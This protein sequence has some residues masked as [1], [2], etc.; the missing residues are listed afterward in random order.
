MILGQVGHL[1]HRL[2]SECSEVVGLFDY[3]ADWESEGAKIIAIL[4][5]ILPIDFR[6]LIY[7]FRMNSR[8]LAIFMAYICVY[9]NIFCLVKAKVD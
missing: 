2:P 8:D 7:S 6:Q 3:R 1:R 9:I 5:E 4:K